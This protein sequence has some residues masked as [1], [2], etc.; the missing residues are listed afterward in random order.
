MFKEA[1]GPRPLR[2]RQKEQNWILSQSS[3]GKMVD[4]TSGKDIE[5][6]RILD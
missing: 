1:V 6:F 3:S 2:F 4:V 5:F